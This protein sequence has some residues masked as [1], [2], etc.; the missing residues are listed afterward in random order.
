MVAPAP[1]VAGSSS[2][3]VPLD[4]I[5][6]DLVTAVFELAG[7]AREW[8]TGADRDLALA[9]LNRAAW[10]HAW[11]R[12]V[13]VAAERVAAQVDRAL[14]ETAWEVRMP[15]RRARLLV[16][17]PGERRAIAG[18]LGAGGGPL[19]A[20][21]DALEEAIPPLRTTASPDPAAHEA[22]QRALTTAARRLEAAWLV[23]EDAAAREWA[24]WSG[25]VEQLRTWRRPLWPVAVA[26]ALILATATWMGLILGGY[27]DAPA[28][29]QGIAEAWWRRLS[30]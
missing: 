10:L 12:A 9:A 4:D 13:G 15:R 17:S 19:L 1:P 5:R 2:G 23:L 18:R 11:E 28:F 14:Q 27:L 16:L 20:S 3:A 22:W 6:Y 26:G 30:I 25:E 7:E 29:F 21:L 24:A 8:C